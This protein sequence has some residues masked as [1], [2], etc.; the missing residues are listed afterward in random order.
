MYKNVVPGKQRENA[1]FIAQ[2]IIDVIEECEEKYGIDPKKFFLLGTRVMKAAWAI[3][4]ERS[5]HMC[6]AACAAHSFTLLSSDFM[7]LETFLSIFKDM[8]IVVK[9][10]KNHHIVLATFQE[11]QTE[12]QQKSAD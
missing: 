11:K 9:A 2:V 8:K 6:A 10:I 12:I 5:P 3:V 1:E 7:K 4:I